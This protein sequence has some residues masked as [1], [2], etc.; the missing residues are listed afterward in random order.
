MKAHSNGADSS[1]GEDQGFLSDAFAQ[2]V[3][4]GVA[5]NVVVIKTETF[6]KKDGQYH[7]YVCTEYQGSV[8]QLTQ[9]LTQVAQTQLG[10]QVSDREMQKSRWRNEQFEKSIAADLEKLN[11]AQ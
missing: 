2:Q 9:E 6:K 5:R 1:I 11:A 8:A 3:A 10:Q 7:V 4:N